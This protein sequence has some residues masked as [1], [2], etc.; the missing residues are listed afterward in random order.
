M[1][2]LLRVLFVEDSPED[3]HLIV[4]E[5][6]RIGYEVEFSRV[7]TLEAMQSELAQ[8]TWDLILSDYRMPRF[9][10]MRALELVKASGLDLPFIIISGKIGEEEAVSALKAGANDFVLK[11]HYARLGPAIEREL[12]E[13]ESRRERKK[14]EAAYRLSQIHFHSLIEHAPDAIVVVREN[15]SI[16]IVN[17]QTE[18][19]FEYDRT[20]ML[21]KSVEML[22]PKR[23]QEK[24]PLH[25]KEFFAQPRVR[26]MGAGL[27]LFGPLWAGATV[28]IADFET[29]QSRKRF[30]SSLFRDVF[31][32]AC[33]SSSWPAPSA[34][35]RRQTNSIVP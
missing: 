13:A 7:E 4:R 33:A 26:P 5:L 29:A 11:G 30:A 22:L 21:G 9:T 19:L 17:S 2:K 1:T 31:M 24:H 20:E 25:G 27:E 6:R 15:G 16:V 32:R 23:F 8:K 18:K 35:R 3:T 28:C 34:C 10:V 14:I 12:R